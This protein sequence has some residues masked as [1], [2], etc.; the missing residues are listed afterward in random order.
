[1]PKT[2]VDKSTAEILRQHAARQSGRHWEETWDVVTELEDKKTATETA[3]DA[4]DE[5]ESA[6]ETL[7]TLADALDELTEQRIGG[8]SAIAS[9]KLREALVLIEEAGDEMSQEDLRSF[10]E[11]YENATSYLESYQNV[12]EQDRYPGKGEDLESA[13]YEAVE[14]LEGLADTYEAIDHLKEDEDA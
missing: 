8:G 6:T 4:M 9:R 14:Q 5:V 12:V 3:A 10:V 2:K 13:W 1:M 11:A 7:G